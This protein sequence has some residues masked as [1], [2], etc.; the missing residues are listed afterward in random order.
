M[1]RILYQKN[2]GHNCSSKL[3]PLLSRGS[4]RLFNYK[5]VIKQVKEQNL[6]K[7]IPH[8]P[9]GTS[10]VALNAIGY[11]YYLKSHWN[12]DAKQAARFSH[13]T[14][15]S[16]PYM[17]REGFTSCHT[18]LTS[19]FI[20]QQLWRLTLDSF[21]IWS[22]TASLGKQCGQHFVAKA[23]MLSIAVGSAFVACEQMGHSSKII[24]DGWFGNDAIIHG[25][26]FSFLIRNPGVQIGLPG[27]YFL[28]GW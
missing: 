17:L 24:R 10:L 18:L 19:H 11:L 14:S 25:L 26:L 15:L 8:T 4:V 12:G 21:I 3:K 27:G 1:F 20:H 6:W 13:S 22:F 2:L 16:I 9:I 23:V 28:A 7:K 5:Q